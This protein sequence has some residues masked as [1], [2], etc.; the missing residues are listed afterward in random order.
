M[1]GDESCQS[2]A[3]PAAVHCSHTT[4]TRISP[5]TQRPTIISLSILKT[6]RTAGP[7]ARPPFCWT[8]K[9]RLLHRFTLG[10]RRSQNA[11]NSAFAS[12]G[13][14]V[15]VSTIHH[16]CISRSISYE[17]TNRH[18]AECVEAAEQQKQA[19]KWQGSQQ[20]RRRRRR[21]SAASWT[22]SSSSSTRPARPSTP[23]RP[24]RSGCSPQASSSCGKPT[25]GS[26]SPAA[27]TSSPATRRRS[28]ALP[29]AASSTR[30]RPAAAPASPS[31]ARTPTRPAPSA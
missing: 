2:N 10:Y 13:A 24:P 14:E 30:R 3:G 11:P 9:Q 1:E 20:R 16:P 23:S 5:K 7:P 21:R 19:N 12:H 26:S 27:S 6:E 29:W 18:L 22:G 8:Q 31:L 28:W 25:R 17:Q 4:N 15:C